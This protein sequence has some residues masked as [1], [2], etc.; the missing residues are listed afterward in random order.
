M[1]RLIFSNFI[2]LVVSLPSIIIGAIVMSSN[3]VPIIIW[4]QNIGCLLILGSISCVLISKNLKLKKGIL[5]VSLY[6]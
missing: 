5:P 3:K 4:G 2:P 6:F 1:R